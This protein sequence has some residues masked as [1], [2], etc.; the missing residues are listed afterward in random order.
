MTITNIVFFTTVVIIHFIIGR[1]SALSFIVHL[2]L[3]ICLLYLLVFR[4]SYTSLLIVGCVLLTYV[5]GWLLFGQ[6]VSY[7][8][9]SFLGVLGCVISLL[10]IEIRWSTKS[11]TAD[12]NYELVHQST[13]NIKSQVDEKNNELKKLEKH[14]AEIIDLFDS[15]KLLNHELSFSGVVQILR[16][17]LLDNLTFN[18]GRLIITAATAHEPVNFH[19]FDLRSEQLDALETTESEKAFAQGWDIGLQLLKEGHSVIRIESPSDELAKKFDLTG[20]PS[21]VFLLSVEDNLV[22]ILRLDGA[23]VKD[24]QKYSIIA[25]QLALQIKKIN[26]YETVKELSITDGLTKTFVRRYFLERFKEE[27]RRSIKYN[28]HL[29]VLMID[30]DHFKMYNDR[31]GHLVGDVTLKEVAKKIRESI[32]KVDILSRYGGEEFVVVLPE[33]NSEGAV[34]AGERI[35]SAVARSRFRVYDEQTQVTVSIGIAVFPLDLLIKETNEYK[36]E[37]TL[38]LLKIADQALYRAKEEGRNRVIH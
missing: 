17:K 5:F 3:L 34:E 38:D 19:I 20:F 31:Y 7:Y 32:R 12:T 18:S 1:V 33:T 36:D 6:H 27:L 2:P 29:S 35:R 37:M 28:H 9:Q 25:T 30:I 22:G 10:I 16:E 14:V 11:A 4:K 24:F 8:L 15:A 26:L 21:F 23:D 13:V